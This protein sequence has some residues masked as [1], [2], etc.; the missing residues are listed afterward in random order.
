MYIITKCTLRFIYY[1]WTLNKTP[2][3]NSQHN[4]K[5]HN[6]VHNVLHNKIYRKLEFSVCFGFVKQMKNK[7]YIL[8]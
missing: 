3:R 4:T 8:S 6:K 5:L 2:Q 7:V 1:P